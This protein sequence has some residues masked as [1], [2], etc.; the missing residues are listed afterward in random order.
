MMK[1]QIKTK[2]MKYRDSQINV[3]KTLF[4][5]NKLG[6]KFSGK[7]RDFVLKNYND[8]FVTQIDVKNVLSYFKDNGINWWKGKEPTCHTLSSQ[9]A[10]INH[11]YSLRN[12]YDTVL[13]IARTIDKDIDGVEVLNNDK[14]KWRGYISFEVVSENDHL[15]EKK[16]T[17]KKLTRGSQCTSIDA[18]ILARK[19]D[20]RILLVFEWKYVEHYGNTDKSKNT[21]SSKSGETRVN[22]YSGSN[23]DNPNLIQKS[24]QLKSKMEYKGSEYFYEPFYQLMRQTLWA[25]QMIRYKAEELIKA[26]DF[27]HV[28]VVPRKNAELRGMYKC[29]GK[30]MHTTWTSQLENPSKYILISPDELLSKLP[31]SYSKLKESLSERY[32][33]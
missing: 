32:W 16:G 18:V 14:E 15:N 12:D 4:Q 26:D 20:K 6:G 10:C 13:A 28:H 24:K 3:Q 31:A 21:K 2:V 27:I 7:E 33:K 1:N 30:D 11:L 19:Q 9:I 25:E 29:S 22:N 17:N 8:N 23:V 5:A